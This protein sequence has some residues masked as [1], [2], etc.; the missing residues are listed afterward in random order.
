MNLQEATI[1][2]LQ[3]K[4]YNSDTINYNTF[5]DKKGRK[6]VPRPADLSAL[7]K[8]AEY[9]ENLINFSTSKNEVAVRELQSD[10]FYDAFDEFLDALTTEQVRVEKAIKE[11]EKS[12][13]PNNGE[14][15]YYRSV[16]PRN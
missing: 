5:T 4:G 15:D 10:D 6:D 1:K 11:I 12:L 3:E 2:A 9:L 13:L 8:Y 7:R 16:I 14:A